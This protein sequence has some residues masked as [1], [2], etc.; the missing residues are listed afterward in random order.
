MPTLLQI[1]TTCN[2]G[3][4]GRLAEKIG[5][6]AMADGYR[7]VIAF[8]RGKPCSVSETI[9]T[10][11]VTDMYLHALETR[12]FDRHGLGS[13]RSTGSLIRAIEQIAPDIVHLHN[14]HGY[15]LNYPKL[16]SALS[17]MD[18]PVVW[19]LHDCWPLTG[20]CAHFSSIGCDK[21]QTGC[22]KCPQ[23]SDY[24][25]SFI[26]DRSCRNFRDKRHAFALPAKLHIVSVCEWQSALVRS[27][28]IRN[29]PA[30]VIRNGIDISL[31]QATGHWRNNPDNK[32]VV[33][34]V[35]NIWNQWKGYDDIVKLRNILPSEYEIRIVG[36]TPKQ[37]SVLP[38]GIHN[39]GRISDPVQLAHIYSEADVFVCLSYDDT[40]PTT[41][42]ES[43]S[44]GTPIVTYNTGGCCEAINRHTGI[45]VPKGSVN[46]AADSI[47]EICGTWDRRSTKEQCRR[48]AES[49]HDIN[50]CIKSYLNLY[51]HI[52]S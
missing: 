8:G 36:L 39:L 24:P 37:A 42:L 17:Q 51:A 44:C 27:S 28:H 49:H 52:L 21:W 19:T 20:H 32:F 15:Y 6:A 22:Y 41:L 12:L 10:S 34:G 46:A 13:R 31:F 2:I 14:I 26:A 38:S 11:S 23:L 50:E 25:A 35:A 33:L 30:T 1:N 3:S 16:F 5:I 40:Y 45:A 43:L 7:S 9:R 18:I 48:Y 29:R 4:H 47:K